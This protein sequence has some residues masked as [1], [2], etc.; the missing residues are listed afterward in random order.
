VDKRADIWSFGAVL[1]EMLA[2]KKAFGG[3][4]VS[5]TLATVMKLEPD[6]SALPQGVPAS[7]HKLVRR[8]L[9]K[10]RKQRLPGHR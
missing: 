1:Y 3:E 4:S 8:C 2:G 6:C 5:D 9:T 10:D 7:V